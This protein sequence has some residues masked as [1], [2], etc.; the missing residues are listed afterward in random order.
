M[1]ELAQRLSV[2]VTSSSTVVD[3]TV[4]GRLLPLELPRPRAA[5]AKPEDSA[6]AEEQERNGNGETEKL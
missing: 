6:A 4:C 5:S 1:T 2:A 3:V